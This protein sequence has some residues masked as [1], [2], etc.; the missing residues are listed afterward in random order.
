MQ[1]HESIPHAAFKESSCFHRK[2][3]VD[4]VL[5]GV[6]TC[7]AHRTVRPLSQLTY[8]IHYPLVDIL[9]RLNIPCLYLYS[10]QFWPC[11]LRVVPQALLPRSLFPPTILLSE[12]GHGWR[13]CSPRG[14]PTAYM[15]IAV[16]SVSMFLWTQNPY[17]ACAYSSPS[18]C[19]P[20]AV[21][22]SVPRANRARHGF[23]ENDWPISAAD[24]DITALNESGS[25]RFCEGSGTMFQ[26]PRDT[27]LPPGDLAACPNDE[28]DGLT[29][30][31]L[32]VDRAEYDRTGKVITRFV[33]IEDSIAGAEEAALERE[34]ELSEL[35]ID[36]VLAQ[37][38]GVAALVVG[39]VST[40]A[41][42]VGLL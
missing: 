11:V 37:D 25:W 22:A 1:A 23:V 26:V 19:R 38:R 33:K 16:V 30:Y 9:H 40:V 36:G 10:S 18:T 3:H 17:V 42:K 20:G 8:T 7:R 27:P 13:D 31:L 2:R 34:E 41:E 28:P 15:S 12:Q 24:V 39:M 6:V 5:Q 29:T 32:A 35:F 21:Q 14:M 4:T